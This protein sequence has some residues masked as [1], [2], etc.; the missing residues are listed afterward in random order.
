LAFQRI[1]GFLSKLIRGRCYDFKNIFAKNL[2]KK[3]VFDLKQSQIL[4]KNFDHNIGFREKR[5]FFRRK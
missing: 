1:L 5:Q 2:A 3:G 4:Q